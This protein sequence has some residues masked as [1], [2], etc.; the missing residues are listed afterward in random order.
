M[1]RFIQLGVLTF[2][3]ATPLQGRAQIG[4]AEFAEELV[5]AQYVEAESDMM[6][7]PFSSISI[8]PLLHRGVFIQRF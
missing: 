7:S 3:L 6:H 4:D 8:K 5:R 1:K 2:L